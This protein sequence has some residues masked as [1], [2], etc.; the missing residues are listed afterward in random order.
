[1]HD[2]KIVRAE[3]HP[4]RSLC[5]TLS[6]AKITYAGLRHLTELLTR[7]DDETL[8]VRMVIEHSGLFQ[9]ACHI[10]IYRREL[11]RA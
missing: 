3:R 8:P 5:L 7:I 6:V 10:Q 1:M 2:R 9:N 11:E 4:V